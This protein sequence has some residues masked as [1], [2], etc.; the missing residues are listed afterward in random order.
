MA[1]AFGL[2]FFVYVF[3]NAGMVSGILPVVGVPLPFMSYGGTAIITLMATFGL[4][5]SIHTHR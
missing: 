1:G 4:V 3:V 2:S 5:M